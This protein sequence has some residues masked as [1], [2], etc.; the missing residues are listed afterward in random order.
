ML[1]VDPVGGGYHVGHRVQ[2]VALLNGNLAGVQTQLEVGFVHLRVPG[3][4]KIHHCL[5]D[6]GR[7][8]KFEA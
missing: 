5:K 3:N 2:E 8:L 4:V 1:V 7:Y 6:H